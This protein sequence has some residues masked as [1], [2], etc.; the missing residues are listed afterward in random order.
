MKE[1]AGIRT[2]VYSRE[3]S[4]RT[5]GIAFYDKKREGSGIKKRSPGGTL[6]KSK[7]YALIVRILEK[8]VIPKTS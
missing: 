4:V 2:M 3:I 5:E 7:I 6:L 8:P 1:M